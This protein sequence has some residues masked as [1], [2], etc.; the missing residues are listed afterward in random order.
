MPDQRIEEYREIDGT[1]RRRRATERSRSVQTRPERSRDQASNDPSNCLRGNDKPYAEP[2][3]CSTERTNGANNV[4]IT[5][6][7]K[8]TISRNT[9]RTRRT[10]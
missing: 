1:K 10:R 5:P 2:L 8:E 7:P 3:P 9:S 6:S 4:P